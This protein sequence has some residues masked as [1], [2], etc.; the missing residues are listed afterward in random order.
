MKFTL[1]LSL[2][3]VAVWSLASTCAKKD[4]NLPHPHQGLL[5]P[6]VPGPFES[7]K[8]DSGDEK[9]LDSGKPVM[10]QTKGDDLAGGAICVQDVEAPKEAVWSQIL[11]LDV[12][13]GKVPKVNESKNYKVQQ[14]KDGT[15]TIKTKM[16]VGVIPGYAVS[17]FSGLE[18]FNGCF[19]NLWFSHGLHRIT[20]T[21]IHRIMIILS[22]QSMI[23]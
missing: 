14:N 6:Y 17:S 10:K 4:H 23:P 13:K 15:C 7:L 5:K 22:H 16:V 20:H 9:I 2:V 19:D 3:I 1:K 18:T 12:Y 8:L 21:S 11:D